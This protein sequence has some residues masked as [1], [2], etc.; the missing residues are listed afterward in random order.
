VHVA[1]TFPEPATK[2][3]SGLA[4]LL[5]PAVTQRV[6]TGVVRPP[7]YTSRAMFNDSFAGQVLQQPAAVMPNAFLVPV[8]K[9]AGWWQK[10]WMERHTYFL[11]RYDD[12]GNMRSQGHTLVAAPGIPCL[13]RRTYKSLTQSVRG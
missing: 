11:P 4:R 1:A 3:R 5:G 9:T 7:G 2:F 12:A 8:T 10:D 13:L 6:L